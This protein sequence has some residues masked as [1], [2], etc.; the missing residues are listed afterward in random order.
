[1]N[2]SLTAEEK[3]LLLVLGWYRRHYARYPGLSR[4]RPPHALSPPPCAG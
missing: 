2:L 1:M 3:Q 4:E